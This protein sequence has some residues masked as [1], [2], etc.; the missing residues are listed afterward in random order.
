MSLDQGQLWK[1]QLQALWQES[2]QT[3]TFVY[4]HER[5]VRALHLDFVA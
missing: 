3:F 2:N 4:I 5:A 1:M